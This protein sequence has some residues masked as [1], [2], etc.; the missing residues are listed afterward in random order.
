MEGIEGAIGVHPLFMRGFQL[1]KAVQGG[2]TYQVCPIF[3]NIPTVSYMA[4]VTRNN[5]GMA[6]WIPNTFL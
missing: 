6:T 5:V 2:N 4:N 3:S 1:R